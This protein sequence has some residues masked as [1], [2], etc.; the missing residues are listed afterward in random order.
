MSLSGILRPCVIAA[1]TLVAGVAS[2]QPPQEI[3]A[4]DTVKFAVGQTRA[5][6]FDQPVSEFRVMA[7]GIVKVRPVTDRTFSIEAEQP[8][9]V[10]AIAYGPDGRVVHSVN[11]AVAGH[12]VKVYGLLKPS[13]SSPLGKGMEYT[14][15]MCTD[16]GCGRANP[17]LTPAPSATSISETKQTGDG[18]SVTTTREYR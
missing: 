15:F 14:A 1:V 12:M 10:L 13:A 17:D 7:D 6:M 4:T 2:A 11:L 16:T 3:T 8:G 5:F 9:E 18:N